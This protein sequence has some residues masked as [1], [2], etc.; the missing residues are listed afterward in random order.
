MALS[1]DLSTTL[2][3][4]GDQN[5][6]YV[7]AVSTSADTVTITVNSNFPRVLALGCDVACTLRKDASA[8]AAAFPIAAG[9]TM[10]VQIAS[11]TTFSVIGA[12][13]GSFYLFVLR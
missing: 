11:T 10:N 1:I 6:S 5:N 2:S 9:D 3:Y 4:P 8:V 13:A 12:S 7:L